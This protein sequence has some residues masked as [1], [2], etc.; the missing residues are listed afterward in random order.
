MRA[1]ARIVIIGSLVCILVILSCTGNIATA[2]TTTT[3]GQ[4]IVTGYGIDPEVFYP[5]D[6]GLLT[7]KLKNAGYTP[8]NVGIPAHLSGQFQ[9]LN[10]KQMV[11]VGLQIKPTDSTTVGMA[12]P[13]FSVDYTVEE[14]RSFI[15]PVRSKSPLKSTT[16]TSGF[17]SSK[18]P[19]GSRR[20]AWENTN[21]E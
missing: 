2:K 9:Y 6:E 8:V 14:G 5:G 4:V 7:V 15:N 21:S 13:Y 17:S 20:E 10:S 3:S 1:T 12:Y 18:N 19:T 16:P 11:P